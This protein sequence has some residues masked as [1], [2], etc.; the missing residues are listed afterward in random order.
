MNGRMKRDVIR[1]IDSDWDVSH[2]GTLIC[3]CGRRVED[4]GDCPDGH[5][6]PLKR[7]GMI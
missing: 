4:D 1:S 2:D 7:H 3:P 6:S 5:V